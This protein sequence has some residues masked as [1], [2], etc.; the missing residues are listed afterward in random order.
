MTGRNT[1][2]DT[3]RVLSERVGSCWRRLA[4]AVARRPRAVSLGD[5][6]QL[7]ANPGLCVLNGSAS[8]LPQKTVIVLGLNRGGTSMVA[9]VLERLG[10]YMGETVPPL[11]EDRLLAHPIEHR[12]LR[13]ARRVVRNHD[14]SHETWGIK[15]P[16]RVLLTRRWQTIFRE[17]VYVAVFRDTMAIANRRSVSREKDLFGE[18]AVILAQ[19]REQ[20]NFL[21]A[22]RRPALLVS[23]EKAL[24]NPTGFAHHLAGFL[25]IHDTRRIADAAA[26]V[27]PS[28]ESYHAVARHRAGWNGYLDVVAPDQVAGWAFRTG[29]SEP[30]T[31]RLSVNGKSLHIALADLPRADVKQCYRHVTDRCGFAFHL[32]DARHLQAGDAVSVRLK[33]EAEDINNSPRLCP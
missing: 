12:N 15:N 11:Y 14:Q 1:R 23:Y 28:P 22:C 18:L 5:A 2:P 3:T 21:K 32:P 9:G 8:A 17:P 29:D 16:A 30:V 6:S 4:A 27:Q 31:V 7:L 19:Y 25:G 20:V 26:F 13:A 24:I 33:G 10:I